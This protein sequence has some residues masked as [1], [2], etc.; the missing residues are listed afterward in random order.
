MLFTD[1]EGSTTLARQVGVHWPEVLAA[2]H[3]TVGG[4]IESHGGYVDRIDGDA[5]FALFADADDALAA[6]VEVQTALSGRTWPHGVR[7]LRVREGLHSGFV[8]RR[9]VGYVSI[10]IHRAARVASAA[11][12]GQILLTR[13]TRGLL[14]DD[15]ELQDLGEHLLKDFPVPERLFHVVID[16]RRAEQ[17]GPPR[18]LAPA[19]TNLPQGATPTLG[20]EHDIRVLVTQLGHPDVRCVTLTGTGGVGKTRLAV[21]VALAA[22]TSFDDGAR[23]VSLA[24]ISDASHV[25]DA[26][27]RQLGVPTEGGDVADALRRYLSGKELLL[28][29]DNLEHLLS[30]VPLIGELRSCCPGLKVLATSREP[31]HLAGEHVYRVQPLSLPGDDADISEVRRAPASALFIACA[32][33]QDS[34]FNVTGR[35]ARSIA[36]ICRRLDGLPLAIELAAAR[37]SLLGSSELLD[38]LGQALETLGHGTGEAPARQQTLRATLDWSHDLLDEDERSAFASLAVFAGGADLEAAEAVTGA[39]LDTLSSL[40]VKNLVDRRERDRRTRLY[41]L[42]MVREYAAERLDA[43]GDPTA[44]RGRHARYY[45]ELAER[46]KLGVH[47]NEQ[48]SW[49]S[50]LDN[51]LDNFRAAM[52]WSL[53]EGRPD[54]AVRLAGDLGHHLG[55]RRGRPREVRYWLE[56][57]LAASTRLPRAVRARGYLELASALREVGEMEPA[58]LRCKAAVRLYREVRDDTGAA[59]AL[60]MLSFV[61]DSAGHADRAAAVASESLELA[62]K[63]GDDWVTAL[64]LCAKFS[65]GD[66]AP[67]RALAEEAIAIAR[68]AEDNEL[69]A[70]LKSNIGFRALEEGELDYA[71]QL[72]S[73]AVTLQRDAGEISGF[74][75]SLPNLGLIETL[76]GRDRDA[77][78][79]LREVLATCFEY[80]LVRP[81]SEALVAMAVLASRA[82]DHVRAARLCGAAEASS[83]EPPSR[84]EERLHA[85]AREAAVAAL[86]EDI[87]RRERDGGR[88]MSFTALRAYALADRGPAG[89]R[90]PRP[91]EVP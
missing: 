44:V 82:L 12:G 18:A 25:A 63:A 9:D 78:T 87:W 7:G 54:L 3:E 4:T 40:V 38:R 68:D 6:A 77:D 32:R 5:F 45:V 11:R 15:A 91:A 35:D 75:I 48:R 1:I 58:R 2:H 74:V 76:E 88:A 36:E 59:E 70:I 65:F 39:T 72:T 55:W 30:A 80:G 29:L 83:V 69:L 47:G 49:A 19:T 10:E 24:P 84:S 66:F 26:V 86:G 17:Y 23:F 37:T 8:E 27:A 73:D 20:R 46:A 43:D 61:E 60:A 50:R 64:A 33:A 28:V 57:G 89:N 62:R 52:A 31:L 67:A 81:L 53:A 42:E 21:E 51:E 56:A 90:D 22:Q 79:T 85:E 16:G 13:A 41:L 14:R 34:G 71:R